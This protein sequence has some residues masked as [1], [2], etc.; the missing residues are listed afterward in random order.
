MS[1]LSHS[2]GLCNVPG[3]G[4]GGT[5]QPLTFGAV[6][7]WDLRSCAPSIG[8]MGGGLGG[9]GWAESLGELD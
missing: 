6:L 3:L 7:N 2:P 9:Y 4:G 1:Q 5:E 8:L